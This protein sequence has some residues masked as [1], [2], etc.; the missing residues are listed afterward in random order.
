MYHIRVY[1]TT[2]SD[3]SNRMTPNWPISVIN[4]D[5]LEVNDKRLKNALRR[6]YRIALFL[7]FHRFKPELC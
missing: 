7:N 3:V 6:I 2:V 5:G 4:F 1:W